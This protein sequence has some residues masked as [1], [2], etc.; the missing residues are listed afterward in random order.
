MNHDPKGLSI[1]R[2]LKEDQIA[3][4][5]IV[6]VFLLLGFQ[7]IAWLN[8]DGVE[9]AKEF[10]VIT[11]CAG[12]VGFP[13][14]AWRLYLAIDLR[15]NGVL[16]KGWVDSRRPTARG[17]CEVHYHFK[18]EGVTTYGSREVINHCSILPSDGSIWLLVSPD[19]Y[20]RHFVIELP[21]PKNIYQA[22]R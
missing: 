20:N 19:N 11:T 1:W 8:I 17:H 14:F 15:R 13:L 2:I 9:L 22:I 21:E 3:Q 6:G 16:L 10:W 7:F 12:V 4:M 5:S 18:L